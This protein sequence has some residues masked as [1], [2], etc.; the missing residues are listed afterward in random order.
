MGGIEGLIH[1]SELSWGR[2][3]HPKDVVSAGQQ[4]EVSVIEIDRQRSRIALSL[5]R[6]LPNPWDTIEDCCHPGQKADATISSVVSF[7]A[8]ARLES[9]LD[10]LIHASELGGNG[11]DGLRP[12]DIL[13]KGQHVQ[14]RILNIDPGRQRLGLSLQ[15]PDE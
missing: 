11:N 14:V 15:S 6:M 3:Q 8:F 12:N 4:V 5:K 2:V 9:G 13:S 10:G 7:G 1:I